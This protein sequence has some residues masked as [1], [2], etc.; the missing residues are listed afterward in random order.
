M[1]G[2]IDQ[3]PESS[4]F[5]TYKLISFVDARQ[6]T[7][8][9]NIFGRKLETKRPSAVVKTLLTIDNS[10]VSRFRLA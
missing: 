10:P 6:F 8:L 3:L 7:R 5:K 1:G 9:R 4:Q 2:Q